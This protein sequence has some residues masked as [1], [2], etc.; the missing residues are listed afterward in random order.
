MM[1]G[2]V[3]CL[4]VFLSPTDVLFQLKP[5]QMAR[6]LL[7]PEELQVLTRRTLPVHVTDLFW[8]RTRL[9][10]CWYIVYGYAIYIVFL[11]SICIKQNYFVNPERENGVC[12]FLNIFHLLAFFWTKIYT[13]AFNLVK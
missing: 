2:A 9:V 13:K 6:E 7:I 12:F 8:K 1:V 10:G 4:L 11:L 5:P 3:N